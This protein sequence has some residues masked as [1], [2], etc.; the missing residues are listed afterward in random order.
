MSR[1]RAVQC[2]SDMNILSVSDARGHNI[3]QLACQ[4]RSTPRQ[5]D[6]DRTICLNL[7]SYW[8]TPVHV[9]PDLE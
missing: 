6:A 4:L 2:I 1:M 9:L 8:I 3:V 7:Q 5:S